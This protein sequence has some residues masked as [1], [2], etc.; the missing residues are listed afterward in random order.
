MR[1]TVLKYAETALIIV[2]VSQ[3]GQRSPRWSALPLSS[4]LTG[5]LTFTLRWFGL[6]NLPRLSRMARETL[7]LAPLGLPF[8]FPLAFA[9]RWPL[10]FGA[11][12]SPGIV[13]A[14]TAIGAWMAWGP[15]TN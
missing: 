5:I 6:R 10:S 4:P 1:N 11:A 8:V 9:E 15:S 7:I 3:V 12:I 14:S 13:L 2:A